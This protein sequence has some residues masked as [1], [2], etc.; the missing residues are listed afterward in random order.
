MTTHQLTRRLS[1]A[2]N[3]VLDYLATG[4]GLTQVGGGFQDAQGRRIY[5]TTLAV[6]AAF[7]LLEPYETSDH[8]VDYRLTKAGRAYVHARY[9]V[10]DGDGGDD[11]TA[12]SLAPTPSNSPPRDTEFLIREEAWRIAQ[13]RGDGD[14]LGHWL[15]AEQRVMQSSPARTMGMR[16]HSDAQAS[17]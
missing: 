12:S 17:G 2:Q 1:S 9:D 8:R 6:L 4:K 7:E 3:A 16:E 11:A 13:E 5:S 15:E 10:Q 14:A